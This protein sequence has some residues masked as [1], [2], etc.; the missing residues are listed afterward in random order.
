MYI[1]M[2]VACEANALD[3][4][5]AMSAA[6]CGFIHSSNGF[7]NDGEFSDLWWM[8]ETG[9]EDQ[10]AGVKKKADRRRYRKWTCRFQ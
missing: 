5:V 6:S 3:R 10:R 8:D 7:T 9:R 2:Y 1:Y 4:P